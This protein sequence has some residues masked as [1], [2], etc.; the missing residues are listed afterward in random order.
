MIDLKPCPF[1]GSKDPIIDEKPSKIYR[2]FVLCRFCGAR[3]PLCTRIELAAMHWNR[4]Y[5]RVEE[6][7]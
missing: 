3:G 2:Y 1:C 6:N 5:E 4:A 7:R